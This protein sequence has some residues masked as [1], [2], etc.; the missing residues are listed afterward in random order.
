MAQQTVTG[1]SYPYNQFSFNST[2]EDDNPP[3]TPFTDEQLGFRADEDLRDD[4]SSYNPVQSQN[5]LLVQIC[6]IGDRILKKLE[7]TPPAA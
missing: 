3:A 7:G 4:I 6:R 1:V 5:G 2:R